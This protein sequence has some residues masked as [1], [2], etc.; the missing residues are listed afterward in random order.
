MTPFGDGPSTV[1]H[2]WCLLRSAFIIVKF[3][4]VEHGRVEGRKRRMR[5]KFRSQS[6]RQLKWLREIPAQESREMQ[7]GE[8]RNTQKG[9][10]ICTD[11]EKMCSKIDNSS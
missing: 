1:I 9:V 8:V 3:R 5:S 2:V 6:Q 10:V 11:T 7:S 4:R